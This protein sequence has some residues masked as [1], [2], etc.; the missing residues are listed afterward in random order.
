MSGYEIRHKFAT[1]AACRDNPVELAPELSEQAERR[2]G[3]QFKHIVLSMFRCHLKPPGSMF[4]DEFPEIWIGCVI[5]IALAIEKKVIPYPAA[6]IGMSDALYRGNPV[7]K[8]EQPP[9]RA[10]EIAAGSGEET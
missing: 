10:V 7:V 4:K 1:P 6:N 3:H 5:H 8:V 9:V 2:L